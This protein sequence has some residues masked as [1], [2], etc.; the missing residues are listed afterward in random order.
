MVQA[1]IDEPEVLK[2]HEFFTEPLSMDI[3]KNMHGAGENMLKIT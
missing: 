2:V 1:E 3:L